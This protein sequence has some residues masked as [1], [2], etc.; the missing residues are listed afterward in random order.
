MKWSDPEWLA[1]PAGVAAAHYARRLL[2]QANGAEKRISDPEDDEALHDFRVAIRRLRT[3]L[4][5]YGEYL[6]LPPKPLRRLRKMAKETNQA[7]D[8]EVT[9]TW[10][11]AHQKELTPKQ[12]Y[13]AAWLRAELEATR[14]AAYARTKKRVLTRWPALH[15]LLRRALEARNRGP[16]PDFSRASATIAQ[17]YT[18][19]FTARMEQLTQAWDPALAHQTRIAGKRLRYLFEP[20]APA[21]A[22]AQEAVVHLKTLQELLGDHHD[23]EVLR[24]HLQEAAERAAAVQAR[25]LFDLTLAD[26]ADALA[27]A[28]RSDPLPGLIALAVLSQRE[29]QRLESRVREQFLVAEAPLR[30][31]ITTAISRLEA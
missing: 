20:L 24:L 14:D 18:E 1:Q 10:L 13:G 15:R 28:R 23:A 2:K 4:R 8:V 26:D 6:E 21:V 7:R 5:A 30:S 27:A 25:R 31:L 3:F 29:Q 11:A 12:R 16:I 9:L 17:H 22:E 19:A